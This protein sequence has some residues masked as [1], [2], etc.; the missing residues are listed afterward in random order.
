M[1]RKTIPIVRYDCSKCPG[2]CCSYP[3][4]EVKDRDVKRLARHFGLDFAEAEK[5]FT[6]LYEPGERVLKHRK[7]EIYGSICRFFDT[8]ARRCTVYEARPRV[9]RDYPNGTR[10]G[11]YDFLKFERRHQDDPDFIPSA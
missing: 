1:P 6:R 8:D 3:R 5:R 2:Y 9:C 7:D 11:Y 10:C 4:I